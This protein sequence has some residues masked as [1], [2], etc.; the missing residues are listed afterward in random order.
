MTNI[1]VALLRAQFRDA[2]DWLD[3][4]LGDVDGDLAHWQPGGLPSPIGAQY[5]HVVTVED[6]VISQLKGEKPLM[7]G[8]FAGKTGATVLPPGGRWDQWGHEVRVDMAQAHTY[9]QA[10]Y[11]ATD[12]YLA[13]LK[14]SQIAEKP[15]SGGR[16]TG[17]RTRGAILSTL[18]MNAYSHAGEIS[19]LKGLQGQQGYPT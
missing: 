18:L 17:E 11:A 5:V 10:V 6:W 8:A 1:A 19:A 12:T 13:S 16:V 15:D 4:T 3:G 9:A 14:D 2:H 7:A